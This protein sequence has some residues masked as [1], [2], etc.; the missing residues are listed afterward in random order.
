MEVG[1]VVVRKKKNNNNKSINKQ[2]LQERERKGV[3]K[4]NTAVQIL[5]MLYTLS[6]IYDC[7]QDHFLVS[8]Y[9][10][11]MQPVL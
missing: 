6:G 11:D 7:L 8:F 4:E 1:E 5:E 9:G 2:I 10:S 3:L